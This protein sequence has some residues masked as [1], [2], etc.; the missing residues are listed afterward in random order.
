MHSNDLVPNVR[1]AGRGT[2]GIVRSQCRFHLNST[3]D[4]GSHGQLV[5]I[6]IVLSVPRRSRNKTAA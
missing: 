1:K 3:N 6:S 4:N 2:F 5:F